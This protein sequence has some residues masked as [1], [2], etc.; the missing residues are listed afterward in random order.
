[1][2]GIGS[3]EVTDLSP[4]VF[5]LGDQDL[6]VIYPT[7]EKSLDRPRYEFPLP[8]NNTK[9]RHNDCTKIVGF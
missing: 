8:G 3:N 1:M 2:T 4:G 5:D 9:S 7:T 6:F